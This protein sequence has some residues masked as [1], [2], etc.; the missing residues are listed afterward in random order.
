MPERSIRDRARIIGRYT[1][2]KVEEL[3]RQYAPENGSG[4]TP[5]GRARLAR[6][7]RDLDGTAPSWML[8]GDEIFT[9]WPEDLPLPEDDS[10]ELNAVKTAMELYAL[11]QQSKNKPV[12]QLRWDETTKRMTFG[13]ACR[14]IV[15]DLEHANGVR[16]K[17]RSIET[18]PDFNGIVRNL[19]SLIML[20]RSADD[21]IIQLDY[22]GFAEDLLYIQFPSTRGSVFQRWGRD[23]YS[24][25]SR[26]QA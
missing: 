23:F 26:Q 16:R 21:G 13:R 11:H 24:W 5:Q 8:V 15:P 9:D 17:L 10:K 25:S 3:Q 1:A 4:S 20:M 22:R 2:R 14:R 18:A 19:R 12:A 6:L 7:R